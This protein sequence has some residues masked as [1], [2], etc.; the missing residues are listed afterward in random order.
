MTT[1]LQEWLDE[2]KTPQAAISIALGVTQSGVWRWASGQTR[3]TLAF[4]MALEV[5]TEGAVPARSWFNEGERNLLA[6]VRSYRSY[7]RRGRAA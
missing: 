5:F 1:K 3:P 2:T 6:E 4:A 7:P